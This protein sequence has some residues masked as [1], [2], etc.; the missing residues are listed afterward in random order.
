MN[1]LDQN[2]NLALESA[3][4]GPNGTFSFI[5]LQFGI[6]IVYFESKGLFRIQRVN[7]RSKGLFASP[8]RFDSNEPL[9]AK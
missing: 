2:G 7:F 6:E 8:A 4:S 1:L 3:I 9:I 5:L